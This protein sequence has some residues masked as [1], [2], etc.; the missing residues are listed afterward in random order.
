MNHPTP[1]ISKAELKFY[2]SLKQKKYRREHDLFLAEGLRLCEELLASGYPTERLLYT[3]GFALSPRGGVVVNGFREAGVPTYEIDQRF[4][5]RISDTVHAQGVI[6][7]V[8]WQEIS[9]EDI[10]NRR[11]ETLLLVDGLQNPGNL[12]TMVRTADWFGV[13]G[14]LL[15]ENTVEVTNPK[16]V[17]ATMGALFHVPVLA[18]QRLAGRVAQLRDHGFRILV[19]DQ[20]SRLSYTEYAYGGKQA[21]ILGHETRG[22]GPEPRDLADAHLAIPKYGHG[23]SL[24]V[25]VAAGILLAEL[26]RS[27]HART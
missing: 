8:R 27:A 25:A 19:A 17:R 24:N 9:L 26:S 20:R 13:G 1:V 23:D 7:V 15:G 10:L 11:P 5:N 4:L 6:A 14:M 18:D 22:V 3:A 16:V 12:G 2:A 21:L